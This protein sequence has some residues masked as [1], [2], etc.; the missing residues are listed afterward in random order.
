MLLAVVSGVV[1]ARTHPGRC[2]VGWYHA[3]THVYPLGHAAEHLVPAGS[4]LVTLNDTPV[5]GLSNDEIFAL[6][7]LA[8]G[9]MN[10]LT[11]V[12][13]SGRTAAV[14]V[15]VEPFSW[16]VFFSVYG[17]RL[18][19]GAFV[20]LTGCATFLLRPHTMTGWAVFAFCLVLAANLFLNALIFYPSHPLTVAFCYEAFASGLLAIIGVHLGLVFPVAHRTVRRRPGLLLLVYAVGLML[21]SVA[22]E[23]RLGGHTSKWV[24]LAPVSAGALAVLITRSFLLAVRDP[25]EL[26]R[27]RARI[28]LTG[29]TVGLVPTVAVI[30]FQQVFD[31]TWL[32]VNMVLWTMF[33]FPAALVYLTV[34]H[35]TVTARIA[36]RRG[37]A[38]AASF[39]G[40]ALIG[41]ALAASMTRLVGGE[42][43]PPA[44]WAILVG[45]GLMG[46]LHSVAMGWGSLVLD[47]WFYPKQDR[48]AQIIERT[49]QEIQRSAG[50]LTILDH[51]VHGTHELC[52]A[53][54][55]TAFLFP[56]HS[57]IAPYVRSTTEIEAF[58]PH[59]LEQT[60]LVRWMT[61]T[62]Q[63]V[64]RDVVLS[65]PA[66]SN[67][68]E[69]ALAVFHRLRADVLLPLVAE[70]SVIGGLAV[71]P[72]VSGDQYAGSELSAVQA[73]ADCA[74]GA[75]P[76]AD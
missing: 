27:R 33:A 69:L 73:L 36:I 37:L 43:F 58:D 44:W 65:D 29:C 5:A 68:K 13:P 50:P 57:N 11:L 55:A 72:R 14:A 46:A 30:V 7:N 61:D 17:T 21:G 38:Y 53:T 63:A 18:G 39:M 60:A 24:V 28:L 2:A 75:L 45:F 52:E 35:E 6:L 48:Y 15:P 25:D 12:E 67:M 76:R 66:F 32:H 40:A 34:R 9:A 31:V 4:L 10:H 41:W 26:V 74:A 20:V 22:L 62:G 59:T 51:L 1:H 8:P 19:L 49:T 3:G 70:G 54:S 42:A 23:L 64:H 71:G 47:R 16:G 56:G